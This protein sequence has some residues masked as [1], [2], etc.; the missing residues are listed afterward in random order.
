VDGHQHGFRGGTSTVPSIAGLGAGRRRREGAAPPPSGRAHHPPGAPCG[1]R[2]LG[3]AT[4]CDAGHGEHR[5]R[6]GRRQARGRRRRE[7]DTIAGAPPPAQRVGPLRP[8]PSGGLRRR[9]AGDATSCPHRMA[10]ARRKARVAAWC[11][12]G[13]RPARRAARAPRLARRERE[14]RP[15]QVAGDRS[16]RSH[17]SHRSDLPRNQARH[18]RSVRAGNRSQAGAPRRSRGQF[19]CNYAQLGAIGSGPQ[20]IAAERRPGEPGR[21]TRPAPRRRPWTNCGPL[22]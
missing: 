9:R 20:P 21:R 4:C 17:R 22:A 1:P 19:S 12:R 10:R 5:R 2:G 6:G 18:A 7:A 15:S 11:G 13:A 8:A 3:A 14:L 16:H